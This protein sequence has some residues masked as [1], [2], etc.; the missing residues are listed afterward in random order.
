MPLLFRSAPLLVGFAAFAV[1]QAATVHGLA[2]AE[3]AKAAMIRPDDSHIEY[4]G[5]FDFRDP[6]G[7]R[8]AWPASDVTI[9][10]R[11]RGLQVLLAEAGK[12][13]YQVVID[14]KPTA[15]LRPKPGDNLLDVASDLSDDAHAVSIVKRTEAL[16]GTGQFKGFTFPDGGTLLDPPTTARHIEVIGDSI[17][18]GYGNEGANEK[19]HFSPATEDAYLAYG[20]V[21]ARLVGADYTCIA[22]SGRKLWPDNTVP[23]IYGLALPMDPTSK[24]DFEKAPKPDAVL[25]NLATNDFARGA[26]DAEKWTA[27]YVEFVHQIRTHYPRAVIYLASGPMMSDAWPPGKH[28]LST[29]KTYLDKV[30]TALVK[31][32]DTNTR[33]LTFETQNGTADGLGADYH[34]SIKTDAKMA[35]VLADALARDL[36]W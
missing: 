7:P 14:G 34:P 23:A 17:S 30:Q 27:A 21:A 22:W 9:R 36:D 6:A 1:L 26:P 2:K 31:S 15:V 13:E 18:C 19:E 8:C 29:L 20:A 10:F 12:D 32:G 5:R 25:I 24:W 33:I 16:V 11:G 28:V 35:G 4:V 3:D